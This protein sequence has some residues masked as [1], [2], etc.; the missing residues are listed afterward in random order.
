[1]GG[2]VME[3]NNNAE[4]RSAM[5]YFVDEAI[6]YRHSLHFLNRWLETGEQQELES[7]IIEVGRE[8]F[9]DMVPIIDAIKDDNY[10][11]G[12]ACLIDIIKIHGL[13]VPASWLPNSA[14]I[15]LSPLAVQLSGHTQ[16]ENWGLAINEIDRWLKENKGKINEPLSA[17][18]EVVN[19]YKEA[20]TNFFTICNLCE[21][22]FGSDTLISCIINNDI[23]LLARVL[24]NYYPNYN[25]HLINLGSSID[26]NQDL[27][28]KD[29]LS[30][31]Q[32]KSKLWLLNKLDELKLLPSSKKGILSAVSTTAIIGGWVGILPFLSSIKNKNL[33][34]IINFDID[35][36][37]HSA[38]VEL[39]PD[40]YKNSSKDART[41]N[42]NNY[43][44]L[45]LI[46]TIV[47]HFENHGE[48]I[49]TLPSDAIILLQ[50]NDMFDVP[51][52]VN[53]HNTLEEFLEGC[54]LNNIL[55]AGELNLYKC[56]RFMAIGK[57]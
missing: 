16:A 30:R 54:G 2:L 36:T 10:S 11:A 25:K 24:G 26:K 13:Y 57:V 39:N 29:A 33:S 49:K 55:W 35:T 37:V 6:G 8:H 48:W 9:V 41:V 34:S 53:C 40:D 51:D 4:L 28:W 14:P 46:D 7:L 1:M 42:F 27:N 19:L 3:T 21:I 52:H 38:A 12:M 15:K 56:T 31:N 47:E 45:L 5:L 50:G 17:V 20:N 18:Q 32:I 22:L 43:P 23:K 44:K